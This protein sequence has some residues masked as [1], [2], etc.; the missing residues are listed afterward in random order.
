MKAM[1]FAMATSDRYLGVFDAFVSAGWQPHK[2]FISPMGEDTAHHQ[3]VIAAAERQ[4]VGVTSSRITTEDLHKLREAGCAALIVASYDWKIPPWEDYLDYAV[5]FHPSPLPEG[6]G[7]YPI[8]RAILEKRKIWGVTCHK[9]S[10]GI[11]SG[12][13]LASERFPLSEDESHEQLVLKVQM[14][15]KN[16]AAQIANNFVDLWEKAT[17]QSAGVYWP[18][19]SLEDRVIDF[20]T[21][22][23]AILHH[24]G[25]FGVA[26]SL[27]RIGDTWLIVKRAVGWRE[28]HAHSPGN[29]AHVSG[30]TIVVA[31]ANGYVA[32]VDNALA[33][34]DVVEKMAIFMQ[35]LH[36]P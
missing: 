26:E 28:A 7:P 15:A 31:A 12:D 11:D 29:V 1:R 21:P 16:L 2:F 6:R 13:I 24:I 20:N 36:A 33:P 5:N 23:E 19:P 34:P 9:I 22:V 17:A 25:A 4:Q 14:A 30:G 35:L 27:A 10:P 32:L 3:A 8:V 18:K